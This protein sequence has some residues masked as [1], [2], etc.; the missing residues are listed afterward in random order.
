LNIPEYTWT[1][2]IYILFD[3]T[4]LN[5]ILENKIYFSSQLVQLVVFSLW[6]LSVT[7]AAELDPCAGIRRVE[8]G[9]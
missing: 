7:S 8:L 5:D 2:V 9:V 1:K 6:V 3:H 4:L